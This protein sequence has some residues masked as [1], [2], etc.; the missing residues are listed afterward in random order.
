MN[1]KAYKLKIYSNFIKDNL[2]L[3]VKIYKIFNKLINIKFKVI[4]NNNKYF[5]LYIY[6]K[7]FKII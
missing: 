7:G 3:K 4:I 5:K 2:S 1:I 6:Y